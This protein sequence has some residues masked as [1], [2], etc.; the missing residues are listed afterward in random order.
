MAITGEADGGPVRTGASMIDMGTGITAFGAVMTALFGRERGG[1]GQRV[2]VSLLQTAVA[3]MGAHAAVC[4]M[5]GH[6]PTRAGSGVSHLAPY[7]AFRTADSWVVT[8]AL[9]QESWRK[10][11]DV[12]NC[13]DLMQD[14]RFHELSDRVSNRAALDA[15][16]GTIFERKT[17]AEWIAIFEAA[18]VVIAPVNRLSE[19]MA[20]PQV[21]A[22]DLV[23]GVDH[24]AGEMR[25]I[26]APML[27]DQWTLR[28]RLRAP[29]LGQHTDEVLDELGY[30]PPAIA[31]LRAAGAI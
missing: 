26:G 2:T 10:L 11:C 16:L 31:G 3:L 12:M 30:D 13:Q 5:T 8:G 24:P 28:P 1:S 22:N 4:V 19:V 6:E 23:V 27:F 17:T 18:Q 29:A 9:N 14:P 15:I 21:A 7:G 20:H 25:L